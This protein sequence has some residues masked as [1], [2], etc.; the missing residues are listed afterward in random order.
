MSNPIRVTRCGECPMFEPYRCKRLNITMYE[1]DTPC[2]WAAT[3]EALGGTTMLT[4]ENKRDIARRLYDEA[5]LLPEAQVTR[6]H[7]RECYLDGLWMGLMAGGMSMKEFA[8]LEEEI[9]ELLDGLIEG[10]WE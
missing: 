8:L 10:K 6:W 7:C 2:D 5:S 1:F 4:M 3:R 9:C